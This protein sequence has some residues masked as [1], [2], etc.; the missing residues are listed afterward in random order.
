MTDLEGLPV[1]GYNRQSEFAIMAVNANKEMEESMLRVIDA[2]AKDKDIDQR[3][4]AIGRTHI[5]QGFM[6]INRA[7]FRPSRVALPGDE[8]TS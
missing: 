6:A 7:I 5:E 3:W 8:T 4:L 1:K 2:L